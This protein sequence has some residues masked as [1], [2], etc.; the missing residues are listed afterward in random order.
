M[1]P[2]ILLPDSGSKYMIERARIT[3]LAALILGLA[4]AGCGTTD[5]SYRPP[6]RPGLERPGPVPV[7]VPQARNDRPAGINTVR[8]GRF[9]GGKMWTFEHPPLDYW[10]EAYGFEPDQTWFEHA[11]LGALR[12]PGCSASLVSSEGLVLT[13]HHCA[14][15][16]VSQV[17]EPGENL[18]DNGFYAG[19][20][21]EERAVDGLYADR[22]IRITDVSDEMDRALSD[23][24]T[25]AERMQARQDAVRRITERITAEAGGAAG[26]IVVEVISLYHGARHSAYTFRRFEDVRLVMAPELQVGYFGG[27]TDNFTYPRYSLDMAF[28]RI[29]DAGKPLHTPVYFPWS[30]N[31]AE[32]G[33]LVFVVGNP[34]STSRL[35]TVAQLAFR[36]DVLERV[37][38]EQIERRLE[39]L[40]A[41]Y[42]HYPKDAEALGIRNQ[43]F[44]LRN[45]QKLYQGRLSTL[46]DPYVMARRM[47]AERDFLNRIAADPDLREEHSGLVEEMEAIQRE[48]L[49]LGAEFGA[50]LWL[51]PGSAFSSSTLRR[52]V[53]A[54]GMVPDESGEIDPSRAENLRRQVLSIS[55]L[56]LDLDRRYLI[57]RLEEFVRYFGPDQNIVRRTLGGREPAEVADDIFSR[58]VLADS[59]AGAAAIQ[60]NALSRTDPAIELVGGFME[61][62]AAYQRAQAGLNARQQDVASRLGRAR[63]AVYR[64]DLPPD[65]TFSLR[66]A[67]GIVAGYPFNGTF[68]PATTNFYGMY[69][70]YYGHG[71]GEW[72]LPS[73]WLLNR[74]LDRSTPLN[75][76]STNDIVGG[77]S[78]SPLLNSR[79]EIVGLAFDGNIHSLG[80]S[81][82]YTTDLARAVSVDS[83]A[84]LE[85]L[86]NVYGAHRIVEEIRAGMLESTVHAEN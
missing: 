37:F 83:R 52:A 17:S 26:G 84:M 54:Y 61:E 5:P 56:P 58:S 39:S 55:D 62:Y 38:L 16:Y 21:A 35:E 86:E 8:A 33:L 42:Q 29:Y 30:R 27:D 70:R 63:Y 82:L 44:S 49:E 31:G 1:R 68:A 22:L 43:I 34:G 76:V 73:R 2:R 4:A 77:N 24:Q 32:E 85:S 81:F 47:A 10:R 3:V 20:G 40:E 57:Q 71:G 78:G 72:D 51:Q 28:L 67:D 9:D 59:A 46:N 25:D 6:E 48:R 75:V 15:E 14:R 36:R 12:I 19:S 13:N 45:A 80:S 23:A 74:T 53:A 11:R 64:T 7:V 50:F 65:A 66:I 79:L 18:L 41:Y 69:D 60:T